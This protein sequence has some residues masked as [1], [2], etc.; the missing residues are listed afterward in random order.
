MN[1][2]TLKYNHQYICPANTFNKVNN[3]PEQTQQ[4][5]PI[6]DASSPPMMQVVEQIEPLKLNPMESFNLYPKQTVRES[7]IS[8]RQESIKSLI[9]QAI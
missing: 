5:K 8:K 3:H 1:A 4:D 6:V 2:K 7:K 9:S